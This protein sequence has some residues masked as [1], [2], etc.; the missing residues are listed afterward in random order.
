MK[1][2]ENISPITVELVRPTTD[3]SRQER[4]RQ[5]VRMRNIAVRRLEQ[6]TARQLKHSSVKTAAHKSGFKQGRDRDE[7]AIGSPR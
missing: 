4:K 5:I 3:I 7:V 2:Q 6:S 1:I